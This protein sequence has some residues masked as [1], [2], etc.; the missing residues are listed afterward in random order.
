MHPRRYPISSSAL[1]ETLPRE[2]KIHNPPVVWRVADNWR[3][4]QRGG[5]YVK[6]GLYLRRMSESGTGA[7]QGRGSVMMED[8][9][10]VEI[11]HYVMRCT[12]N[13][14][15]CGE[16]PIFL[17]NQRTISDGLVMPCV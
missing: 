10:A 5:I 1:L 13:S 3:V 17:L 2:T 12:G 6:A 9:G 7:V 11:V 14:M 16:S 4:A 8:D 15:V